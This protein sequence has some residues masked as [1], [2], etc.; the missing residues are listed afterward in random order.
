MV[1]IILDNVNINFNLKRLVN[2]KDK[3]EFIMIN[4]EEGLVT[5]NLKLFGLKNKLIY[6][7]VK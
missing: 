2:K 7:Y 5:E 6:G 4:Y 1:L 3:E